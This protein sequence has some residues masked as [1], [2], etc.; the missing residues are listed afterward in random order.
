MA[1]VVK[2][3]VVLLAQDAEHVPFDLRHLRFLGYSATQLDGLTEDLV[4][5]IAELEEETRRAPRPVLT[6]HV[7][8]LASRSLGDPTSPLFG[9]NEQSTRLS[10]RRRECSTTPTEPAS[11][12]A[13]FSAVPQSPPGLS[14][15]PNDLRAW[16]DP[17]AR[18]YQPDPGNLFI[19]IDNRSPR[20]DGAICTEG[21]RRGDSDLWAKYV[22]LKYDG[23]VEYGA[24]YAHCYKDETYF[25]LTPMVAGFWSFIH[26]VQEFYLLGKSEAT[27]TAYLTMVNTRNS[28]LGHLGQGW[29]EPWPDEFGERFERRCEDNHV[30]L[31]SK[32]LQPKDGPDLVKEAVK[33]IARRI[34]HAYGVWDLRAFNSPAHGDPEQLDGQTLRVLP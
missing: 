10:M 15:D 27:V 8:M 7:E 5:T 17:N 18:K 14:L 6:S 25:A 1:H 30:Q 4:R 29:R 9:H 11:S 34:D 19:P 32:P 16:L 28:Q 22:L 12:F 23:Y 2:R 24:G 20:L 33:D 26:F 13:I 31:A 21:T 3:N